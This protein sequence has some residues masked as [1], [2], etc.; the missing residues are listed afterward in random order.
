MSD[1]VQRAG[2]GPSDSLVAEQHARRIAERA[3]LRVTVLQQLTAAL[4]EALTTEEVAAVVMTRGIAALA[5]EAGRIALVDPD[6]EHVSVL[7]SA[8]YRMVR[9]PLRL[10][11][12][13]PTNEAIR[14]G[15]S[16]FI[17]TYD[18]VIRRFPGLAEAVEPLVH[19]A[20]ASTP[21]IVRGNVI[22]A[23]TLVFGGDR[24]FDANDRELLTAFGAQAAPALERARLY[25]LSL[26]NQA[27]VR[28][29]RD[30]LA[31]ILSGIAEGVTVQDAQGRVIYANESALTLLGSATIEEI[32]ATWT[33]RYMLADEDGQSL[34]Y[35]GLP[36]RRLLRGEPAGELVVEF[37]DL[38]RGLRQWAIVNAA[39][40][41]DEHGAIQ[42]VVNIFRDI[43]ERKRQMDAAAVLAEAGRVLGSTLEIDSSLAQ[44]AA[45]IVPH[46]ADW[47][48]IDLVHSGDSQPPRRVAVEHAHPVDANLARAIRAMPPVSDPAVLQ[49]L[50]RASRLVV[51]PLNARGRLLGR[52]WLLTASS[53][54]AWRQEELD[55]IEQLGARTSLAID[56]ALLFREAQEQAQHQ[57]TLNAALREAIEERDRALVDVREALR[58][59]DE[60]LASASHDLKN[61]LASIKAGA[62]LLLRRLNAT[63]TVDFDALREGLERMDAIATRAAGLVD[64]LLDLARAQMGGPI[65]LD[66]TPTD[67][68]ALIR[69]VAQEQQQQT[70]RHS[71]AVESNVAS[72]VGLW[73][74]RRLGRVLSNLLD[75]AVK[76]SPDGGP[77]IVRVDAQDGWL[78]VQISDRGIGIPDADLGRVFDRFQRARNVE[79]RIGGTGLGLAS[80]RHIVEGHGGTITVSSTENQGSTFSIR[81]PITCD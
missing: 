50:A 34:S 3:L 18:E 6:G 52:L 30:Q 8:G 68:L 58:T 80:V 2:V 29:S 12:S 59:R 35:D 36:G 48:I 79:R 9:S 4:A 60:F 47:C 33:E 25:A 19:G 41:R 15:Q 27:D 44:L 23:L 69:G 22:G 38:R 53:E 73:D 39:A 61:P 21:L 72:V 31:A 76:Y 40:V 42:L 16:L 56:R 14:T 74:A 5:A 55:T 81:L 64:E 24:A 13:L 32:N 54:P 17:G 57:V 11:E 1:D 75:N 70:E 10:D 67:L 7:A 45:I 78:D 63:H 65:D 66:R 77:V 51:V 62:Q 28:R 71:I 26:A 37:H 43:T 46:L 20:L 49:D